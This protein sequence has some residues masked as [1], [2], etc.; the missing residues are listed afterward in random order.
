MLWYLK[1][2]L[3]GCGD[4]KNVLKFVIRLIVMIGRYGLIK[5]GIG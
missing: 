1:D 5:G 2:K 3:V 4:I